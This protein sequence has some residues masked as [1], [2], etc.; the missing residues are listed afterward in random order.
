MNNN[1]GALYVNATSK[2]AHLRLSGNNTENEFPKEEEGQ[3]YQTAIALPRYVDDVEETHDLGLPGIVFRATL[4]GLVFLL[5]IG[6]GWLLRSSANETSLLPASTFPATFE[7]TIQPRTSD[8]YALH[9]RGDRL[10][11]NREPSEIDHS[12]QPSP[13]ALAAQ[14]LGAHGVDLRIPA[15]AVV[16]ASAVNVVKL[17]EV[18]PMNNPMHPTGVCNL[19]LS[20]VPKSGTTW[21]ER[22]LGSIAENAC[23]TNAGSAKGGEPA[24][25]FQSISPRTPHGRGFL[26]GPFSS[27]VS[28]CTY[29]DFSISQKHTMGGHLMSRVALAKPKKTPGFVSTGQVILDLCINAKPSLPAYSDACLSKMKISLGA[30]IKTT[31]HGHGNGESANADMLLAILRDP[32]A[33]ALSSCRFKFPK[34]AL[35]ECPSATS[36][37]RADTATLAMA[38]A[39]AGGSASH[40]MAVSTAESMMLSLFFEDMK[41]NPTRSYRRIAD[42]MGLANVL[43]DD[44]L[45][46]VA[47]ESSVEAMAT[48]ESKHSRDTHWLERSYHVDRGMGAKVRE[49]SVDGFMEAFAGPILEDMDRAMNELLPSELLEMYGLAK[50]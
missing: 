31:S 13:Q 17:P 23:T 2:L 28:K 7:T 46:N 42:M 35:T 29:I 6:S 5:G 1:N 30:H 9:V 4:V 38:W 43:G 3:K 47:R 36:D 34:K 26:A 12:T 40:D 10:G 41:A 8:S 20:G 24:C 19:H 21:L 37:F 16:M 45:A 15:P 39:R 14:G 48:A 49:G 25:K 27:A 11:S 50:R 44:G 32:R 18:P 22:I 33:V